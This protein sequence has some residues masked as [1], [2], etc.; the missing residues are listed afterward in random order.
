MSLPSRIFPRAYELY[1]INLIVEEIAFWTRIH[2]VRCLLSNR[3]NTDYQ[4]KRKKII[5]C[6]YL[7]KS[8]SY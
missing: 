1:R 5:I 7:Q 8:A 3:V 4:D 2:P 6:G